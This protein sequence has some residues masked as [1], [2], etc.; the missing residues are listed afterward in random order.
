M[1]LAAKRS[2]ASSTMSSGKEFEGEKALPPRVDDQ[3]R[4]G[5][6]LIE[7]AHA[8]PRVFAQVAHADIEHRPADKVDRLEPG[9]SSRGAISCIM[10]GG[11]ARG[12]EALMRIAQGD[13]DK[14]DRAAH[15]FPLEHAARSFPR[16]TWCDIVLVANPDRGEGA[17]QVDVVSIPSTR[18]AASAA[19]ARSRACIAIMPMHD[20]LGQ[21][22]IVIGL[23][24]LPVATKPSTR[25]PGPRGGS[26]SGHPA[27]GRGETSCRTIRR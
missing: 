3:R 17:V 14:A 8:L 5:D 9:A 4:F 16:P 1:P 2:A 20:E 12:P 18:N 11:H 26:H 15:V 19:R 25:M 10:R 7:N 27:R 24:L 22:R 13:I 6:P 21:H 23:N